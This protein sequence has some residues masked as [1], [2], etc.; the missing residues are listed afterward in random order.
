MQNLGYYNG[1]IGLIEEMTVPMNDRVCYF[2]DGI[3]DATYCR[4]YH[5]YALDEHVNR[6]YNGARLVNITP[7]MEKEELKA[8]LCELVKKV[9]DDCQFVYFQLTRGTAMRNHPFPTPEVKANLWITLTPRHVKDTY[10][11]IKLITAEDIRFRL[12]H[13]KTLNLL[14]SVLAA[15]AAEAAGADETVLHRG[16][17]VTECAHSNVSM[18]KDGV[19]ITPPTDCYILPGVGRAH[20]LAMCHTLGFPTAERPFTLQELREADEIIVSSASSFCLAAYMLDG[21]PVGGKDP[22]MLK[23]LQDALVKDW[24]EKTE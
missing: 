1:K 6:F 4:H 12:C 15:Q 16:E 10:K 22:A 19:F 7:P 18:I 17:R 23:A 20:L 2:G 3:Y 9:D 11:K 24:L 8:L 14:P 5:I 13:I 21:Q